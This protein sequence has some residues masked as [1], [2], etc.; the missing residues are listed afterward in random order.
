MYHGKPSEL[1]GMDNDSLSEVMQNLFS[2][3]NVSIKLIIGTSPVIK[4]VNLIKLQFYRPANASVAT[5]DR[6]LL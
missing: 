2:K 5:P 4:N 3:I 1:P 6:K